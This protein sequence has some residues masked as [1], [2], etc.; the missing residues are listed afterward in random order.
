MA[1]QA[2]ARHRH[3]RDDDMFVMDGREISIRAGSLDE[4]IPFG[5]SLAARR[6]AVTLLISD[7][8]AATPFSLTGMT[9]DDV[10]GV[11]S[12]DAKFQIKI[13]VSGTV[14]Q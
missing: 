2:S 6:S 4:A 9:S 3:R 1:P 8:F 10:P 7:I 5:V 11:L 14:K 13:D 12:F